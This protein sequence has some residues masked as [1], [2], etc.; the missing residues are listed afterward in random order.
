MLAARC[1]V[2]AKVAANRFQRLTVFV[3][4]NSLINRGLIQLCASPATRYGLP[5]DQRAH[6]RYCEVGGSVWPTR[7]AD[8]DIT[9]GIARILLGGLF[10]MTGVMKFVVPR[11]RDAG[12]PSRCSSSSVAPA[13]GRLA[14]SYV[15]AVRV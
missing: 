5:L 12:S 2:R 4:P 11:L 14:S 1:A 9:L 10:I 3:P 15:G 7:K 13:R 6:A 8:M